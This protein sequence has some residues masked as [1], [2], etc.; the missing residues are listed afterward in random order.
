MQQKQAIRRLGILG[1]TFN[2][3]H[4][5][6]LLAAHA[7]AEAF[8]LERV[9]LLPCSIS[10]F[11]F[12]VDNVATDQQRYA[13]VCASALGDPLL[14]PCDLDLRRGGISYAY[15]SIVAL[16]QMYPAAQLFFI[17]GGDALKEIGR[18]YRIAELLSLCDLITLERPGSEVKRDELYFPLPAAVRQKIFNGIIRGRYCEVSASEIRSRIASGRSIR[19]LV[20]SAVEEYIQNE[21][22]YCKSNDS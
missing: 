12:E 13:M 16:R 5:G 17:I 22:L 3:I 4:I 20:T 11:K 7:A 10:P 9:L 19:Y 1:G 21:Q 15:D 6:H 2:P 14:E 8:A 18:W